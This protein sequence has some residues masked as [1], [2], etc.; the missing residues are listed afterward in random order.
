MSLLINVQCDVHVFSACGKQL[1][2]C[3]CLSVTTVFTMFLSLDFHEAYSRHSSYGMFLACAF[4]VQKVELT[5]VVQ[6]CLCIFASVAPCQSEGLTSYFAQF[7]PIRWWCATY[8]FQVKRS[9][10][11]AFQS[12]CL[13]HICCVHSVA[14]CLFDWSNVTHEGTMCCNYFQIKIQGHM[15]IWSFCYVPLWHCAYLTD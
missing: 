10:S 4:S 2:R 7:E 8:H 1:Y 9:R 3:V 5:W 14:P 13:I 11:W 6:S 12:F 15:V